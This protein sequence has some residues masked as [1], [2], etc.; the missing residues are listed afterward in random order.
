MLQLTLSSPPRSVRRACRGASFEGVQ[1]VVDL[2]VKPGN[3]TNND[4][5]ICADLPTD[6]CRHFRHHRR[7]KALRL[8]QR[9][10]PA[11]G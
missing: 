5:S 8:P 11:M 10:Q 4:R 7:Q 6:R 2:R 1:A 3:C 9:R